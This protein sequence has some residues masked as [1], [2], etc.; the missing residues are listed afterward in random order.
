MRGDIRAFLAIRLP[1]DVTA[2]LGHLT[3]QMAQ[4]RVGGLKP[5]RPENMHLTLKFFGNINARQVESIVDTVTHTVK[6]IRPFTLRLG[7]VGAYPNNRS[8]RVL[9]VGL[10]GDVA[11]LQDAHR[12]IETALEQVSI[13]PDPREFRPHLTIA[14][15]RDHASHADRR[16]AAEALFSAEFRSGI[17]IPADHV[18]LIRSVLRPQGPQYT[19][20]A[21]ISLNGNE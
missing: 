13:K 16:R 14:R 6:S 19:P 3:D 10:D 4:A 18:S 20:L 12:R 9:W 8:P 2:A 11:P 1:D 7:N 5:V 21:E 17:S 15:I